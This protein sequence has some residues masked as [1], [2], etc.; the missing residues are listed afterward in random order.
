MNSLNPPNTKAPATFI[1]S[2]FVAGYALLIFSINQITR[3][4]MYADAH[5]TSGQIQ[6]ID[7]V[8]MIIGFAITAI[9]LNLFSWSF[10]STQDKEKTVRDITVLSTILTMVGMLIY[11]FA[12][13]GFVL[14]MV[15]FYKVV[16]V[17]SR[18]RFAVT[19]IAAINIL[20]MTVATVLSFSFR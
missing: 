2:L 9:A 4:G 19:M 11:P 1:G 7:A 6:G 14:S 16:K 15:A 13:V 20:A 10:S 18:L 17:A 12:C 3:D 5:H 8:G